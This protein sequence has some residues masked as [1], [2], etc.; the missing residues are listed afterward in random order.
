MVLFDSE[1][2]Y[3]VCEQKQLQDVVNEESCG[4]VLNLPL[5][6]QLCL[7]VT[8]TMTTS[9]STTVKVSILT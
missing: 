1:V 3:A 6:S 8:A 2:R 4:F 7:M 9:A 5:A